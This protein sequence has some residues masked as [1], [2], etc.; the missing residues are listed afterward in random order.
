[1]R[2]VPDDDHEPETIEKYGKR[3]F[4]HAVVVLCV[5]G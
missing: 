1:M 5:E 2:P 4:P 3:V